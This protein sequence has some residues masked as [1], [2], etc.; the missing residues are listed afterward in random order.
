MK[1]VGFLILHEEKTS[2]T[3]PNLRDHGPGC[4]DSRVFRAKRAPVGQSG[5]QDDLAVVAA[6]V[7]VGVR[8]R[9]LREPA[10]TPAGAVGFAPSSI[11]WRAACYTGT[12]PINQVVTQ[13]PAAG[14]S[15]GTTQVISLGVEADNCT[16]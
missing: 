1:L 14:T 2:N 7:Q 11:N 4:G 13:S 5:E 6:G 15:Y 16:S 9:G 8:P 10:S 3:M 12:H